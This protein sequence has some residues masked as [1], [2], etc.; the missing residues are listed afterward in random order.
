MTDIS[1]IFEMDNAKKEQNKTEK[2]SR[3]KKD[4]TDEEKQKI[5]ERLKLGKVKAAE[6]RDAKQE[7]SGGGWSKAPTNSAE[8]CAPSPQAKQ[9]KSEVPKLLKK[10]PDTTQEEITNSIREKIITKHILELD[11]TDGIDAKELK[12][13]LSKLYK[14]SKQ[15]HVV[16]AMNNYDKP[17][18]EPTPKPKPSVQEKHNEP[19]QIVPPKPPKPSKEEL[20]EAAY[21]ERMAKLKKQLANKKRR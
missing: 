16:D 15:K 14:A 12:Q 7:K 2:R 19:S 21:K 10:K 20:E 4:Y 18:P 8:C 9:E 5:K 6:A 13:F 3:K 1:D 11:E 17:Q